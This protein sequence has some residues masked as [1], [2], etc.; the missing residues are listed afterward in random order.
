V[1]KALTAG[2]IAGLNISEYIW[3]CAGWRFVREGIVGGFSPLPGP[4]PIRWGEGEDGFGRRV[5]ALRFRRLTPAVAGSATGTA[6]RAIPTL[7]WT[8]ACGTRPDGSE[9]RPYQFWR[10]RRR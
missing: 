10:G 9:S 8:R 6:Q 3:K 4:L 2:G 7:D 5:L 1:I